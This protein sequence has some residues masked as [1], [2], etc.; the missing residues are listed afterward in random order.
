MHNQ[1][2]HKHK[3]K[4]LLWGGVGLPAL[5]AAVL[6]LQAAILNKVLLSG[7]ANYEP[8]GRAA[9]VAELQAH[10]E[11]NGAHVAADLCTWGVWKGLQFSAV[12]TTNYK[13]SLVRS[14]VW[15]LERVWPE[16]ATV[17]AP[18]IYPHTPAGYTMGDLL[19][20][21]DLP[22]A[23]PYAPLCAELIHMWDR[24]DHWCE[25]TAAAEY[26]LHH[27][28]RVAGRPDVP[29]VA[30]L[31]ALHAQGGWPA[32]A[33]PPA[34]GPGRQDCSVNVVFPEK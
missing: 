31:R 32:D 28:D 34:N 6:L 2:L 22:H 10:P 8:E 20:Y 29:V 24:W 23:A 7:L 19:N 15:W 27:L 9:L 16:A 14:M 33:W 5:F 17:W 3:R 21:A 13:T 25:A 4:I 12:D 11:L 1:W 18:G 26:A 30:Y